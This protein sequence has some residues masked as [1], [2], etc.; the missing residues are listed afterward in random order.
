L[1]AD[2]RYH[3]VPAR[4][5]TGGRPVAVQAGARGQGRPLRT[6]HGPVEDLGDVPAAGHSRSVGGRIDLLAGM[7]VGLDPVPRRV[8]FQEG[9]VVQRWRVA[10][11]VPCLRSLGH[12]WP[13]ERDDDVLVPGLDIAVRKGLVDLHECLVASLELSL[14]GGA[15]KGGQ[16]PQDA[17]PTRPQVDPG[18]GPAGRIRR[19]QCRHGPPPPGPVC[20]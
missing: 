6:P 20:G 14:F 5:R 3:L 1:T 8:D 15:A 9:R 11:A 16:A 2:V 17:D 4:P 18:G 13:G 7:V 19:S 10:P 12:A